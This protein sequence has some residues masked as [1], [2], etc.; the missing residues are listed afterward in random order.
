LW[1]TS[2]ILTDLQITTQKIGIDRSEN[3]HG[4]ARKTGIDRSENRYGTT[5]KIGI[6][7]SENQHLIYYYNTTYFYYSI[8]TNIYRSYLSKKEKS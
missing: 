1:K 4:T 8:Y 6:D 3:R 2:G 5:Q 7:R